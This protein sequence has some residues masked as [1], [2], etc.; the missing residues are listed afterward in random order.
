MPIPSTLMKNAEPTISHLRSIRS[1]IG[2]ES[3]DP[4][5]YPMN[6]SVVKVSDVTIEYPF[7]AR[8]RGTSVPNP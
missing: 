1:M 3:A 8:T 2:S 6:V 7:E 5:G 4:I